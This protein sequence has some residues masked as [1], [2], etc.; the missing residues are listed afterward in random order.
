MSEAQ[1]HESRRPSS[2]EVFERIR[3]VEGEVAEVREQLAGMNAN[4]QGQATTLSRIAISLEQRS[5]TDWKALGSWAAVIIAVIGMA[6]T[7]ILQP[8][9]ASIDGNAQNVARLSEARIL[10]TRAQLQDARESIRA[11]E[12]MGRYKE[13]VDRI[14]REI[15][16][17]H[18]L[19]KAQAR[20]E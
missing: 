7:L 10:D 19:L 18:E 14:D 13:R 4:L 17:L 3:Q 16:K 6:A 2:S 12:E 20:I 1:P 9:R 15:T 8:M 5:A 11:A